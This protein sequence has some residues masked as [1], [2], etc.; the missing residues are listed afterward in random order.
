MGNWKRFLNFLDNNYPKK[1]NAFEITSDVLDAYFTE[2]W[3]TGMT[4]RTY[5]AHYQTLHIVLKI[6]MKDQ[7]LSLNPFKNILK[8][9]VETESRLA[10]SKEELGKI[11]GLLEDGSDFYLLNKPQMRVMLMFMV[12]TGS[13]GQD[14]CQFCWKD[15]V[16]D[17]DGNW[18]LRFIPRKNQNASKKM[19]TVPIH[20]TL[21]SAIEALDI[22]NRSPDA[23]IL[24]EVAKRY[25]KN[26]DGIQKDVMRLIETAG[27]QT[28]R[29]D[30]N[31]RRIR[32][33]ITT[34][35]MHSFR[36]TFVTQA[37]E[38]GIPIEVVRDI[39]GHTS[40]DMTRHYTH[41]SDQRKFDA[42]E[43]IRLK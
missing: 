9:K 10:F 17:N 26:D 43:S 16:K 20:S 25:I 40:D 23:F 13:R 1:S 6:A 5:N 37:I 15:V 3:S 38:S 34:Y 7:F 2:L 24:P 27:I 8:K 30:D 31:V 32:K 14:A 21:R 12:Y 41:I 11:F 29:Y 19:V 28:K 39:V 4:G 33:G 36:H 35:S 18:F 22:E 42:I